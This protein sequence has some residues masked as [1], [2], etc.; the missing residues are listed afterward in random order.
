MEGEIIDVIGKCTYIIYAKDDFMIASFKTSEGKNIKVKGNMFVVKGT[1]YLIK[2]EHD[3]SNPK[4]KDSY[5]AIQVRQDIDF[6]NADEKVIKSFLSS[7]LTPIQTKNI[8]EAIPSPIDVIKAKDVEALVKVK[9]I[10]VATAERIIKGYEAQKDY[11]EAFVAFS[12]YNISEKMVKKICDHF[13]SVNEAIAKVKNNVYS[14]TQVSGIGFSKA[15]NIFLSNIDNDPNDI[16]RI[17]AFTDNLFLT[18]YNDGHTWMSPKDYVGI[19]EENFYEGDYRQ[20]VNYI[21]RSDDFEIFDVEN[22]DGSKHKRIA[23]KKILLMELE[24]VERLE[25]LLNA[26][27][28]MS[29]ENI[30]EIIR[31]IESAQGWEYSE[32]QREAIRGVFETNVVMLQG[33]AGTGKSSV[34]KAFLGVLLQNGYSYEGCCLSGKA[35]DNLTQTTNQKASTIHSMLGYGKGTTNSLFYYNENNKLP[36]NVVLL[37]E[38]SMPNLEIFLAMLKSISKGSKLVMLG[39]FGQLEAIGVGV[40][41]SFIRSKKIPMML[42]KKIHRQAEKSAIITHSISFRNGRIPSE[43]NLTPD[44]ES[45]IYGEMKDLEYIFLDSDDKIGLHSLKRF[46]DM[47]DKFHLKDIQILC[48][49]KKTGSVNCAYLNKHAQMIANPYRDDKNEIVVGYKDNEYIIREGDKVINVKNNRETKTPLGVPKPIFNGN[50]GI[51][52]E[53]N[54]DEKSITVDFDGIGEV[55]ILETNLNDIE[56]GYAIT[57][58]KAQG[59]TIKCVIFALPFHFLLNS[60]ELL[61]TGATRANEYQIIVSTPK[62]LK[63]AVQKSNATK[64]NV[65]LDLFLSNYDEWEEFNSDLKKTYQQD[66]SD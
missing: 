64:K 46:K 18:R 22:L 62:A 41:G 20:G 65:S 23:L 56:L 9:G 37:D 6:N 50:T 48:S 2:A 49:T 34:A 36:T 31:N 43:I 7:F 11:S 13:G 54:N 5:K 58:H 63:A 24:C 66:I 10:G 30:E 53:V 40:M 32:E 60:K 1:E 27:S 16:R 39:D 4:Y 28:E 3:I 17:E 26:E 55:V 35:A 33:L 42:L 47:L 59:S 51:V 52:V 38:L 25:E 12:D 14:L 45:R 29:F 61:Y 19:F 57:I 21:K 8:L 15:D 44:G